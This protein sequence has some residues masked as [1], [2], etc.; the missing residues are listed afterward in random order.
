[1]DT[2]LLEHTPLYDAQD[3]ETV[4]R[5]SR[6]ARQ[7]I[8]GLVE[9]APDDGINAEDLYDVVRPLIREETGID[10]YWTTFEADLYWMTR[11]TRQGLYG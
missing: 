3:K 11:A 2:G 8:Q 10:Y 1:M 5:Q 4:A 6:L 9:S 7:L